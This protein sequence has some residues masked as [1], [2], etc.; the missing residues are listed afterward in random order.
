MKRLDGRVVNQLRG[1]QMQIGFISTAAGSC[2]INYGGTRVL[3][4]ASIEEK[5][6]PFLKGTNM[7]WLTAEYA[8][9]PASTG[10]RKQRDGLKKDGRGVEIGRMIGRALRQ[11]V[12]MNRL[13]PRTITID[14]DVLEADGGTRTAGITGGFAA[15]CQAVDGL[16][17]EGLLKESPIIHQ[18]AA[19]SCGIVAG[20]PMLDL[21]YRED[22]MAGTDMNIIMNEKF[23][24][25]ELQGTGEGSAFSVNE[26]AKMLSL[27]RE[28][29]VPLLAAQTK[30]LGEIA[31]VIGQK[32]KLVIA[33]N[34]KHKIQQLALM[35][36]DRY[37]LISMKDVGFTEEIDETGKTFAENAILKA[38][39]LR[40]FAGFA[41][42]ADDSG[43]MVDALDGAP[44]IH[45]AR[46]AGKHGD[47]KA[48]NELLID[49]LKDIE[50][51]RT[52]QF[53]SAIA[54][55]HPFMPTRLFQGACSGNITFEPRGINGF[56]Y[57]PYFEYENGKTFAEMNNE[58]KAKISHRARA[59]HELL[60]A[61]DNA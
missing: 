11:A 16:I 15:L 24:F 31:H 38:E 53:V 17:K 7:G 49:K 61:L 51:P 3:C 1:I 22:S 59:M 46:F 42:L 50:M 44:G 26:L 27:S 55:A 6:P 32:Q 36:G 37:E 14:C 56:G 43:L 48:N 10:R 21:C 20:I 60:E 9:L 13:G 45:S 30:A 12:D 23:S 18:I 41:S 39:T 35:L 8:M 58:E 2:L 34:N 19:V 52:A 28:G 4:T 33:S 29:I 57:D 54:L 47:D 5:Q 25:I 40:N